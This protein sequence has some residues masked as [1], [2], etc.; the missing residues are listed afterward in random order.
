M[1][2]KLIIAGAVGSIRPWPTCLPPDVEG[3]DARRTV[4]SSEI[5]GSRLFKH[6]TQLLPPRRYDH[7]AIDAGLVNAVVAVD[8][9]G[10]PSVEQQA[11][12]PEPTAMREDHSGCTTLRDHQLCADLVVRVD[13][14][15]CSLDEDRRHA[16][17]EH[18]TR[19]RRGLG[20]FAEGP[21]RIGRTP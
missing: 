1:P 5:R 11:V 18:M 16:G 6:E 2:E 12:A 10:A 13:D 7:V 8:E 4:P 14:V 20:G 3:A 21:P 9:A 19:R 15:G 17:V